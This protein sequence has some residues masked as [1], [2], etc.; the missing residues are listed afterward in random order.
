MSICKDCVLWEKAKTR[1]MPVAGNIMAPLLI[2]GE[3]PG[4]DEDDCGLPF[5]GKSGRLL[6][7]ALKTAGVTDFAITNM[8]RCRPPNNRPPTQEEAD[9]CVHHT[10]EDIAKMPNLKLIVAV[11]NV[12]LRTFTGKQGITKVSGEEW[13]FESQPSGKIKLMPLM[14]PS[15]ILQSQDRE[16]DRFFEHVGRIPWIISGNLTM[17]DDFGE[18]IVIKTLDEWTAL[19]EKL[20]SLKVFAYDTETTGLIPWDEGSA[21]KCIQFSFDLKRAYILPLSTWDPET[22]WPRIYQDL[23]SLFEFKRIGKVGQN[24]KFDNLWMKVIQDIEVKGTIWDTKLAEYLLFG[25]G[26][27]GLK[28]MAYRY[29]RMGGFEK[30]L[31]N[32]P[33]KLEGADL[34]ELYRYGGIDADLT[35]R[36][37]VQQVPNLKK[38][39][40]AYHLLKTLLVPVSDVLMN[41]ERMGIRVD[42]DRVK[43]VNID[44][45][46]L[47]DTLRKRMYQLPEVKE[48]E[49][50]EEKEFNPNS[51]QQVAYILYKICGLDVFKT[52][53]KAKKPATDKEVLERY[54]SRSKLCELLLEYT[55]YEQMHKTF[56]SELLAYERQGRIH[57][58]LWLTETTTGRTSCVPTDAE[59]LTTSGWKHHNELTLGESVI[60]FDV[61][62]NK[63]CITPLVDIHIGKGKIGLASYKH[64]KI[65]VRGIECTEDHN[66]VARFGELQGFIKSKDAKKMGRGNYDWILS[67]DTPADFGEDINCQ[68]A[69][70]IGWA[71]TDGDINQ[72]SSGKYY[73]EI[74]LIKD[75]S[76]IELE[77]LLKDIPHS[78]SIYKNNRWGMKTR[79]GI[80]VEIFNPIWVKLLS[81]NN[82]VSYIVSLS[83]LA[84][85]AMWEAMIEADGSI[86]RYGGGREYIRFGNILLH[87]TKPNIGDA[88]SAL[89]VLLGK[90]LVSRITKTKKGTPFINWELSSFYTKAFRYFP[91]TEIKNVWCPE[92]GTGTWIIRQNG[93]IGITGNSKKPNM[94]N[95]PKGEKDILEIRKAFIADPGFLLCE[96]D[97][98]QHELRVMAEMAN[99]GVMKEA[100]K[101]DIHRATGSAI[102][103][104]PIEAVTDEQRREAKTVN[105][106]II[107]G[108]SK[109]GL[110]QQLGIEEAEAE[111]WL[112]RFFEKYHM[113]KKY[114]EETGAFCKKYGYVEA[115]SG[116]RRYFPSWE[117]FDDKKLKEAVNFPIQSLASDILLYGAIAVDRLLR[118]RK[119]FLVLEV[120]DSLLLNIHKSEL[121]LIDEIRYAM[122]T[123]FRQ[124]MS[125]DSPLKVDVKI[126]ENWGEMEDYK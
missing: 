87:P 75:K 11:G 34:D 25:K 77:K 14:H 124:F 114:M 73:L 22:E 24:I 46:K 16:L 60:G 35:Y 90:F 98:N 59:I 72:T 95:M 108:L 5:V 81:Y 113:T 29:S 111:L 102:F 123:Y 50:A 91:G 86:K 103:G 76:I 125:F 118:G 96:P 39:I 8:C 120:H 109:Y 13:D 126:G 15:Y 37:Y 31:P 119:S 63:L 88:F 56:L 78:K 20:Y 27:T 82:I 4:K 54:A 105:F 44:C 97:M 64:G 106:G 28:Q 71:L 19:I 80:G 69:A 68:A 23:K 26:A 21:I 30:R 49:R 51:H 41:M 65:R 101:G 3:A 36:A 85:L 18:Y 84:R 67:A 110:S 107:Y 115:L 32:S 45:E 58:T 52:T 61:Q 93:V 55:S 99:D 38:Q 7:N 1:C 66:W 12:A 42:I 83:P 48:F 100:L 79:F 9:A 47:T 117:E 17:E 62:K 104:I 33:E 6:R 40:G 10:W 122:T 89:S 112:F 121:G 74:T 2:V 94:Q 70:L 116:R 92:T 57:T 53:D 43:Q